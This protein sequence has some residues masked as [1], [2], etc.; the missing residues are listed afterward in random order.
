MRFCLGL[1]VQLD[2]LCWSMQMQVMRILLPICIKAVLDGTLE[3]DAERERNR[4]AI[5]EELTRKLRGA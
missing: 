5:V 2:P 4:A 1:P 3:R